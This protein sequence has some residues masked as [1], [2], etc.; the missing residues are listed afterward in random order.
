[1]KRNI[2]LFCAAGMSTSILVSR[3]KEAAHEK[4]LDYDVDSYAISEADKKGPEAD[5]ILLGPQVRYFLEDIK[6][7][8]PDKPVECVDMQAYG[9]LDGEK[10]INQIINMIENK[11]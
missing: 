9:T 10:V 11:T 6:K 4:G 1:M 5:I 8:F 7:K 2:I 3:M